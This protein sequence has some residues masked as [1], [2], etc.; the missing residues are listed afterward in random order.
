MTKKI[1]FN[2]IYENVEG[3]LGGNSNLKSQW[4]AIEKSCTDGTIVMYVNC[5]FESSECQLWII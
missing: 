3:N 5:K 2:K 4:Y 1:W